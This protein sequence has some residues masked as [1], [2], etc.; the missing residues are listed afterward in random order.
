ME[1]L[2]LQL[3]QGKRGLV[4]VFMGLQQLGVIEAPLLI[5]EGNGFVSGSTHGM[6]YSIG[7]LKVKGG[8]RETLISLALRYAHSSAAQGT[9]LLPQLFRSTA[10]L[11]D[12]WGWFKRLL[13]RGS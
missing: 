7:K 3:A 13:F 2:V 8:N 12:R 10:I 1:N 9:S 5:S 4:C 6:E 11:L